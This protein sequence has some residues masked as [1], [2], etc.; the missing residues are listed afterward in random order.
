MQNNLIDLFNSYSLLSYRYYQIVPTIKI[1]FMYPMTNKWYPIPLKTHKF[2][3]FCT[4]N[5]IPHCKRW[6]INF[7]LN[8][9]K[10]LHSMAQFSSNIVMFCFVFQVSY[11]V[12]I[13][14]LIFV[15]FQSTQFDLYHHQTETRSR[16]T[17]IKIS[18]HFFTDNTPPSIFNSENR[19]NQTFFCLA[20]FSVVTGGRASGYTVCF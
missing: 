6:E 15:K 12:A 18:F 1:I 10:S 4:I 5:S 16:Y 9:R 2:K 19:F 3:W 8:Q 11:I 7:R 17:T 13:L 20:C 14:H